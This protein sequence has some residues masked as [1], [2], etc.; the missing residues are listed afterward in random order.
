LLLYFRFLPK[1]PPSSSLTGPRYMPHHALPTDARYM[2]HHALQQRLLA[3]WCSLSLSDISDKGGGTTAG[4]FRIFHLDTYPPKI[5]LSSSSSSSST[6][7]LLSWS[8]TET[9]PSLVLRSAKDYRLL[10]VGAACSTATL[11]TG[12]HRYGLIVV[13][14]ITFVIITKRV[15][16]CLCCV[17]FCVGC[18]YCGIY[19]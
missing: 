7:N 10:P 11:S 16:V 1:Q 14:V 17:V 12:T 15:F 13:N 6:Q 8:P 5:K 19:C 9:S 4:S 3:S 2:P 18:V